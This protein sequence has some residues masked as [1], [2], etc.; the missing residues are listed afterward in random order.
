MAAPSVLMIEVINMSCREIRQQLP[1][2]VRDALPS[3][4]ARAVQAH[5]DGCQAC[6]H[7]LELEQTL[8]AELAER[9]AAQEPMPGFESRVLD[10]AESSARPGSRV[11]V[12]WGGAVAAALVLGL[13]IGQSTTP[14]PEPEVAEGNDMA[15]V[16]GPVA[17]LIPV[18]RTVKLAFTAG[19]ALDDVTL[20]LNLPPHVEL[21]GLPGQQ[22][23]RWQVS[24]QQGDN[25]LTLPLRLLFPGEGE[26]VAELDA[27]G[28]QKV[29]RTRLP[30]YPES[31]GDATDNPEE[32]AI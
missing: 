31:A 1:D 32:P 20:T 14:V 21:A 9:F 6:R 27:G 13:W 26:L 17:A 10:G 22:Q 15:G 29:F 16:A 8:R 18:E 25:V 12:A 28:Q 2:F 11:H 23:V 5:L 30:E 3:G 4:E 7:Q 24:L 19:E